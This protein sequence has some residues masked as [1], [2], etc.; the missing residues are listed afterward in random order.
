LTR[1]EA[2]RTV[3]GRRLPD[4]LVLAAAFAASRAA[5]RFATDQLWIAIQNVD[6][7][8]LRSHL[9]QSVWY[10]HTDPPLFGLGAGVV[11]KLFPDDYGSAFHILFAALGLLETLALYLLLVGLEVDRRLAAVVALLIALSPASVLYENRLF[12]DYP[13]LVLLTLAA[14]AAQ[15]LGRRPTTARAVSYFALLAVAVLLRSLYQL[16]WVILAVA[17]VP[18][19]RA[20]GWRRTAVAAAVPLLVVCALSVKNEVVFGTPSTSSLLGANLARVAIYTAP[21]AKR[22]EFVRAGELDR[23]ELVR[24]FAPLEAYRGIVAPAKRRGVPVLDERRTAR[25]KVNLNNSTYLTIERRQLEDVVDFVPRHPRWYARGVK[26]A[27]ERFFWPPT[28]PEAIVGTNKRKIKRWEALYEAGFY[29]S[30]PFFNRVGLVSIAAYLV[31]FA[32]AFVLV[33][34]R[35]PRELAPTF[36]WLTVVYTTA[37]GVLGDLGE[38]YRSRLPLDPLVIVLLAVLGTRVRRVVRTRRRR[39]DSPG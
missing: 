8:L 37:V 2:L 14:L 7:R 22:R 23:V 11:L 6:P 25:G 31:A 12:Y 4:L 20:L 39:L 21:L 9:L 35:E 34:R 13:V 1:L 32:G 29:G 38:N 36:M 17:A 3:V 15:R 28:Y 18:W 24:T 27:I 33:R 26:L 19:S 10:Q 5:C 30:T 16:P